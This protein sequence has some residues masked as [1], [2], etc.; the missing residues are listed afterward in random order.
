M[1][2]QEAERMRTDSRGKTRGQNRGKARVAGM[3][4]EGLGIG[5][6]VVHRV[7]VPTAGLTVLEERRSYVIFR[8]RLRMQTGSFPHDGPLGRC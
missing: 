7:A 4:V 1:A 5:W 2:G 6:W 3:A 8:F